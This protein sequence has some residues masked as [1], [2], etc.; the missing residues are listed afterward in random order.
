MAVF[1]EVISDFILRLQIRHGHFGRVQRAS[2]LL[3]HA[4]LFF[5]IRKRK[6]EAD[7][8]SSSFLFFKM[9]SLLQRTPLD[10]LSHGDL[11]LQNRLGNA[12]LTS[13]A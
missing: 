8:T 11:I 13:R 3:L 5:V 2:S 1:R 12:G 6:K 4:V 7:T 10:N 9:R